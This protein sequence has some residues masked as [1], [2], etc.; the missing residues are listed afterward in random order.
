[1]TAVLSLSEA[2]ARLSAVVRAAR[3]R[4]E[5]TVVT[6][7]G[8]PAARIVPVPDW[9]RPLTEAEVATFRILAD[10]ILAIDRIEEP[11]DA[12]ELLRDGQR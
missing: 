12:V 2:K 5:E 1:M 11:F 8:E 9:R 4:G 3:L 10:T 7:D 6:V